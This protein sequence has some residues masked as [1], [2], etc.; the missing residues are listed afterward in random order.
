M[1]PRR[2]TGSLAVLLLAALITGLALHFMPMPTLAGLRTGERAVAAYGAQYPVRLAGLY[3]VF[4]AAFSALPLPG[5]ELL[6]VGAGALF[7]L[8]EG[9]VLVSFAS[10]IGACG[11][12]LMGR[13][14]LRDAA[15]R[16]LTARLSAL[17]RG[18]E[19]EGALYLFA[20]RMIPAF[21]FFIINVLMG[22]TSLRMVTFYWVSQLGMLPA[23]IAYVNAGRELGQLQSLSGILSP[24]VIISFVVIGLLP[25]AAR[26]L[27]AVLRRRFGRTGG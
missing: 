9:T 20:M 5:A 18:V 8:I 3:L 24:G 17:M 15:R 19:R 7:G 27:L 6:T 16:L 4:V 23:T 12:F 25:L 13:W 14:W 11:A 10:T 1:T 2:I 22:V 21:P 26:R